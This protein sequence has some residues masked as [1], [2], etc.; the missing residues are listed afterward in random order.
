MNT[1]YFLLGANLGEPR[2]Q[3]ELAEKEIRQRVGQIQRAS[4]VYESV[5][6]GVTEQ[7]NF[8]NQVIEVTTELDALQTLDLIQSIEKDLGRVRLTKWGA[9]IIDIDILYFNE[10][11]IEVERLI[12]PHPYI[13][14]RR[15]TLV[16]LNE[17]APD[18]IHPKL[19]QSNYALLSAC[20]DTL[21]VHPYTA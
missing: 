3:L 12:V 20:L 17:L 18:F 13:Q 14:D 2:K 1:V 10:E 8:L 19:Q 11:I 21:E 15:F 4:N 7:P 5:A 16:P 6:W 9:R